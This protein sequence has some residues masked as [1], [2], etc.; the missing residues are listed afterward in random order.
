MPV[1][2]IT[3]D[4][5][6]TLWDLG[7]TIRRAE[8]R[9]HAWLTEHFPR[10]AERYAFETLL[11]SR[12]AWLE[13]HP[14]LHHDMTGMR[15]RWMAYLAH[16]S[17]YDPADLVEPGFD[18][19]W[20]VR[21]QVE[22]FDDALETLE[23]LKTHYRVGAVTNGNADVHR[24][25]IGHLFDFVVTARRIGYAKP[26]PNIFVAALDEAGVGA[27][28]A[29]HI[30]DDPHRDVAGAAAVGMRTVWV[31]LLDANWPVELPRAD[32]EVRSLSELPKVLAEF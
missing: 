19:F 25:G 21:N 26:H 28:D 5:D 17:G 16:E 4:L 24:I 20:D 23:T 6:D 18:V 1:R 14:E 10:I 32:V 27:E 22:L 7:P 13:T 15:R 29:V 3:F 11:A 30:G 9:F 31:N 2:A 12:K 8:L